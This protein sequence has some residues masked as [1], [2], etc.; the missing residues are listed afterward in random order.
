M[1]LSVDFFQVC[2]C[3]SDG[4]DP[5]LQPH[6][7]WWNRLGLCRLFCS[8]W[9]SGTG[10]DGWSQWSRHIRSLAMVMHR[11]W[12][13]HYLQVLTV[14]GVRVRSFL[15]NAKHLHFLAIWPTPQA[16]TDHSGEWCDLETSWSHSIEGSYQWIVSHVTWQRHWWGTERAIDPKRCLARR[17]T[18]L[19][20][21]LSS[22]RQGHLVWVVAVK[23][24]SQ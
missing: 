21:R 17:M 7:P 6:R 2:W 4:T 24:N 11:L 12:V 13:V 18:L 23:A 5:R 9:D 8:V 19:P 22:R 1:Q 10:Y 20:P 3:R 16:S 15:P 14:E